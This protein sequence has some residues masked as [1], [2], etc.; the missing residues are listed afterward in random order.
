VLFFAFV[1]YQKISISKTVL[2]NP[3]RWS[4]FML[5]SDYIVLRSTVIALNNSIRYSQVAMLDVRNRGI[6]KNVVYW[7]SCRYTVYHKQNSNH[8]DQNI[9][10]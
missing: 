1:R 3:A 8:L 9:A 7:C 10:K 4:A 5:S 2:P 6:T